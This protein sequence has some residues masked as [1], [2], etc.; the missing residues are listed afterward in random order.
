MK[1]FAIA[2]AALFFLGGCAGDAALKQAPPQGPKGKVL[3][4]YFS[5][6]GNTE[7]LAKIVR[8]T[9]GGDLLPITAS[10]PY[11]ADY[12]ECLKRATQEQADNAR[13]SFST[14]PENMASYEVIF[15]GYPIWLG[16]T[17]LIIRSFLEAY[18]FSG[19]TL[20]PFC[21]HG[22][23]GIAGSAAVIRELCPGSRILEGLAVT[24]R[25][26]DTAQTTVAAWIKG[27]GL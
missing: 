10:L 4:A 21:T 24:A 3:V 17:P 13:P 23:S 26:L 22:G 27:L 6:T 12:N 9:T 7:T 25:E 18:D 19:K 2:A 11:P 1:I 14:P 15:I 20:I 5:R 16:T 8:E